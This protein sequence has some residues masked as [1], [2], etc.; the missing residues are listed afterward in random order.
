M[1]TRG[2][3]ERPPKGTYA[4]RLDENGEQIRVKAHPAADWYALLDANDLAILAVDLRKGQVQPVYLTKDGKQLID[5]RN[6]CLA[7]DLIRKEPG[8]KDAYPKV[9]CWHEDL[10]DNQIADTIHSLNA[11]GKPRTK[12]TLAMVGARQEA[13]SGRTRKEIAATLGPPKVPI[14]YLN[15]AAALLAKQNLRGDT[16][17]E[18]SK[19]KDDAV[20]YRHVKDLIRLVDEGKLHVRKAF[21]RALKLE[22]GETPAAAKGTGRGRN[23]NADTME[24]GWTRAFKVA[25]EKTD[26]ER[27]DALDDLVGTL[28]TAAEKI[29]ERI[30]QA[31]TLLEQAQ[32]AQDGRTED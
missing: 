13:A 10:D 2:R 22:K 23:F 27:V 25:E 18:I 11:K 20:K 26:G 29:A 19:G 21:T 28:K 1:A 3:R 17:I 24:K 12:S 7:F 8:R 5:G 16:T 30:K 32:A 31:E 4:I 6:R 14:S 15:D 9:V